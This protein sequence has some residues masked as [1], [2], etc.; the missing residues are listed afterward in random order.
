MINPQI[1][2]I[3][4]QNTNTSQHNVPRQQSH[5]SNSKN[6]IN[7]AGGEG[8]NKLK[9]EFPDFSKIALKSKF[10]L[11]LMDWSEKQTHAKDMQYKYSNKF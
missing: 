8:Q 9:P 7:F 5:V 6:S 4:L 1:Q 10:R 3:L 11:N 2:L